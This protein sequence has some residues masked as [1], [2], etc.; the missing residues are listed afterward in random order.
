MFRLGSTVLD[1]DQASALEFAATYQ[2]RWEYEMSLR[3]IQTQRACQ[4]FCVSA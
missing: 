2:Q 3:E 1:P 4:P